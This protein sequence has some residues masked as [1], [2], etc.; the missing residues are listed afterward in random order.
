MYAPNRFVIDEFIA[1]TRPVRTKARL[2]ELLIEAVGGLGFDRV[3][4]SIAY[5]PELAE[6]HWG[7]GLIST[8]PLDW[9]G[10]YID[11]DY[12]RIDPVLR[13]ASGVSPPFW[14]RD[15]SRQERLTSQQRAFLREGEAAGLYNGLGIPFRGP[16]VQKAGIALA[17][18]YRKLTDPVDFDIA[19]AI[20]NHFYQAYKRICGVHLRLPSMARLSQREAEILVRAAHG[21]TDAEIAIV[22][23]IRPTTVHYH[24]RS[25][26]NKLGATTRA[27]AVGSAV[28]DGIIEI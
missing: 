8:Y 12:I 6:V 16:A 26:F 7:F 3:N 9:Q 17:T 27:Q 25:I 23:G 11:R 28:R 10:H 1:A 24:W 18:S 19:V 2:Y 15:L 13:R 20:C 21:R 14:W 4:F 5:D 22:L